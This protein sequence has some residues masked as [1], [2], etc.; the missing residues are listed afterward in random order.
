[1]TIAMVGAFR[2]P[3]LQL[4]LRASL[5]FEDFY[6]AL[7]SEQRLNLSDLRTSGGTSYGD[8]KLSLNTFNGR[9]SIEIT[10]AAI[11]VELRD[12]VREAAD[13]KLLKEHLQTC[14]DTL[15]RALEGLELSERQFRAIL[16]LE[17]EGGFES[18]EA[19]L[20]ERGNAAL[21]LDK[22]PYATLKKDFTLQ[23]SGLDAVKR[24]KLG[25]GLQRSLSDV[26]HLYLV[27]DHTVYG[28]TSVTETVSAQFDRAAQDLQD[29][30]RH[31]GLEP[32]MG[33]VGS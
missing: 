9:G 33:H 26:G 18:V 5:V 27:F 14:E 1:M 7:Q 15:K 22:G 13:L 24:T 23:F 4:G 17:C 6:K 31:V 19:F 11:I 30:M 3:C 28:S 20:G 16:W 32:R 12:L 21:K 8:L 2:E 10:P 29:L 25:L